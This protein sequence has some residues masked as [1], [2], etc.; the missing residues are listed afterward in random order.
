MIDFA[1]TDE[2]QFYFH[3]FK[4]LGI[5]PDEWRAMNPRDT[6]FLALA[7]NEMNRRE[8][9]ELQRGNNE[10]RARARLRR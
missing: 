3:L 9:E 5:T 6:V 7:F 1:K 8:S 2:G 4:E 10:Q